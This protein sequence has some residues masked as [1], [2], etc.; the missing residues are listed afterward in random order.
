MDALV[1]EGCLNLYS[2]EGGNAAPGWEVDGR[3]LSDATIE[4]FGVK[5]LRFDDVWGEPGML[6]KIENSSPGD[7]PI[8]HVRITIERL[9][10]A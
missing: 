7:Y 3:D 9:D 8:G 10:D 4:H 5:Q 6:R 1:V 2:Q